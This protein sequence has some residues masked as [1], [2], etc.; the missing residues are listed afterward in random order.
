MKAF[1]DMIRERIE[2]V[3]N[4]Y[5]THPEANKYI[6]GLAIDDINS[7][8]ERHCTTDDQNFFTELALGVS[9]KSADEDYFGEERK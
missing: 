4:D 2:I 5:H 6:L 9:G 3:A 7:Y 8:L 1:L